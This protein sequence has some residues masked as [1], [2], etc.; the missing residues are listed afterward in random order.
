[1]S[2]PALYA[3]SGHHFI[4]WLATPRNALSFVWSVGLG[5]S[6]MAAIFLGSGEMEMGLVVVSMMKPAKSSLSFVITFSS[7]RVMLSLLAA[8]HTAWK[9]CSSSPRVAPKMSRSSTSSSTPLR[10]ENVLWAA[11]VKASEVAD[12]PIAPLL[13]LNM[14]CS[15]TK[16]VA[17]LS[18]GL[19]RI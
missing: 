16:A 17:Y 19:M 7:A 3:M 11:A 6:L 14:P 4:S 5:K 12:S 15:V 13:Y 1:M 9:F 18:S 8:S 10:P 2:V